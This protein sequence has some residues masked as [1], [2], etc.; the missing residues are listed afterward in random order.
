M[1][2][3][4]YNLSECIPWEWDPARTRTS[5][6]RAL[7]SV[8]PLSLSFNG[9]PG[10][11]ASMNDQNT[12]LGNGKINGVFFQTNAVLDRILLSECAFCLSN[13]SD[14]GGFGKTFH[15]QKQNVSETLERSKIC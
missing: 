13:S 9:S 7:K 10:T 1:E 6:N 5:K 11:H 2:I 14:N 4:V 15:C 12:F 3:P 8:G